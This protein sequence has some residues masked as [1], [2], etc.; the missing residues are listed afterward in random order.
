MASNFS[1]RDEDM[2][3]ADYRAFFDSDILRVWHLNGKKI[4]AR[5]T[6]VSKFTSEVFTQATGKREVKVQPK[7]ELATRSGKAF[8]LPLLLN[9]TNAKT[10]AGLYGKKTGGWKGHLI[11]L[12]PAQV[13]VGGKL[14][15][16]IRI[17]NQV[18]AETEAKPGNGK[19][20]AQGVNVLPPA[21]HVVDI[22]APTVDA[23]G[24]VHDG[25]PYT[26]AAVTTAT[27]E[28]GDDTDEDAPDSEPPPGTLSTDK[29]PASIASLIT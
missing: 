26:D 22:V 23:D 1:T 8:P 15:D 17:E 14:T 28:P 20:N 11:T 6:R 4:T 9:K 25:D 19:R 29:A 12:Y 24:V 21:R 5:I 13:E 3:V 18:P 2:D 16:G 7:L 27:R 10:I